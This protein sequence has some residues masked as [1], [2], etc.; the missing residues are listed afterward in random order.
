MPHADPV[1]R[2]AYQRAYYRAN[3]EKKIAES[4]AR[5][6]ALRAARPPRPPKAPKPPPR[7]K[8]PEEISAAKRAA[9]RRGPAH[10]AWKGDAAAPTTKR[11]RAR[12]LYSL[13][14]VVCEDCGQPAVDRH[15]K[16]GDTG[17]NI[18][19][20]IACLCRRCHMA[21]DG[22]LATFGHTPN[23]RAGIRHVC[24]TCGQLAAAGRWT[25]GECHRCRMYFYK[26][27]RKWAPPP[28][29]TCKV[30]GASDDLHP[31]QWLCMAHAREQHAAR[32]RE[33]RRRRTVAA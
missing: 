3:R 23:P 4:R 28:P 17:N 5:K 6:A 26:T 18:P 29:K 7:L 32:E 9:A 27:G 2:L 1:A 13:A 21:R 31:H 22:R 14:G 15:H 25:K 24:D 8:T 19:E 16:D 30:C 11:I 20:N 33:R 10:P 12:R